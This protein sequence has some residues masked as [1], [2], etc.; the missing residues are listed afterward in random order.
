MPHE[1]ALQPRIVKQVYTHDVQQLF[2]RHADCAG[3]DICVVHQDKQRIH[4]R[5]DIANCQTNQPRCMVD[6]HNVF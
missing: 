4:L 2:G 5:Q 6:Q 3:L 1:L